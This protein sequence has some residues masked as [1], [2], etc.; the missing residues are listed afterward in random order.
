MWAVNFDGPLRRL[1][2]YDLTRLVLRHMYGDVT[3][4]A[5]STITVT[6]EFPTEPPVNPETAVAG[7]QSLQITADSVNGT[8]FYCVANMPGAVPI[9]ST[10]ISCIGRTKRRLWPKRWAR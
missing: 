7:T 5:S 10:S 8:I 2:R 4:V 3:A 1:P 9:T 6:K